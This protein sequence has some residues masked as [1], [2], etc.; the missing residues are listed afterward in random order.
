MRKT[1]LIAML[2]L[3]FL[4]LHAETEKIVIPN[5][6]EV[7][8]YR[9]GAEL[10][11]KAEINLKKGMNTIVFDSIPL[12]ID[13]N[14]IRVSAKN[15]AVILS[16]TAEQKNV[17]TPDKTKA[18]F[19]L[20]DSITELN[21]RI[22]DLKNQLTVLDGEQKII[23]SFKLTPT[24]EQKVSIAELK[25]HAAFYNERL[26]T[27]N[28][29]MLDINT[30]IGKYTKFITDLNQQISQFYNTGKVG[31][32]SNSLKFLISAGEDMKTSLSAVCFCQN[33]GWIPLYDIKVP[34]VNSPVQLVYKGNV[35]QSTGFDWEDVK[36]SLSTRDPSRSSLMPELSPWFLRITEIA[37]NVIRTNSLSVAS[38]DSSPLYPE[39]QS[40]ARGSR[41][42]ETSNRIDGLNVYGETSKQLAVEFSPELSYSI[43]SDNKYHLVV[44]QEKE[45]SAD[46]QFYSVPKLDKDV[47]L[48]ARVSDWGKYDLLEADANI[49]FEGTFVGKSKIDPATSEDTLNL[50]LGKDKNISIERN[51]LKKYTEKKFLS[52]DIEK[53]FGYE[54]K[55]KNNKKNNIKITIE[56][57]YPIS[58]HSDIK[59]ELLEK[60]DAGQDEQTGKLKWTF[61][62]EPGK[63]KDSKLIY[64]ITVPKKMRIENF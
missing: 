41:T 60:S 47:F 12:N 15:K 56:D 9:Q 7:M 34:D 62:L 55:V 31:K 58:T 23:N 4:N 18:V 46:Y 48:V 26:T 42:Y 33:A 57:Q 24:A 52:S 16:V 20:E 43:P 29:E 54:I 45:L 8:V 11:Y 21:Y 6:S 51:V 49:Y 44:L 17:K 38:E 39:S 36:I 63:S 32:N 40:K 61:E 13:A 3:A 25:E 64:K 2:L 50:S 22:A 5:L 19:A 28:K 1:T 30:K 27:I 35:Y 37:N 10:T 59:V 14:N 53:T